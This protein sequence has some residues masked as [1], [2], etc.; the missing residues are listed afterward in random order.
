MKILAETAKTEKERWMPD[1]E[2]VNICL[3]VVLLLEIVMIRHS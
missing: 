3:V 1:L 2:V